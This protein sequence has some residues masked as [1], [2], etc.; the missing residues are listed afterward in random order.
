VVGVGDI[1]MEDTRP[2]TIRQSLVGYVRDVA[3]DTLVNV[4]GATKEAV[5]ESATTIVISPFLAMGVMDRH[6]L[7]HIPGYERYR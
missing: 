5:R 2:I 7:S 4:V 6:V 3:H 1:M